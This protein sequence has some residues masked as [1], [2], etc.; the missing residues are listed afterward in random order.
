MGIQYQ[1]GVG[2]L[3]YA[4]VTCRPGISYAVVK[5]AQSTIAPHEIH[6]HALKHILKYLYVTRNDGIYYWR[7]SRNTSLPP[8]PLPTIVSAPHDLLPDLGCKL[9]GKVICLPDP[10]IQEY[11][12]LPGKPIFT[13]FLTGKKSKSK[14]IL[15]YCYRSRSRKILKYKRH[16]MGY[17]AYSTLP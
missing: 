10:K 5:C 2:E 13:V 4:L 11:P 1:N 8:L 12:V 3:I 9:P 16:A 15:R 6:Y 14:L 17:G 7:Q